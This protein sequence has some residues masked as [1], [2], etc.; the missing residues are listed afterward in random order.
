MPT[1]NPDRFK[2]KVL[3]LNPIAAPDS[4]KWEVDLEGLRLL[5]GGESRHGN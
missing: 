5:V 1:N 3:E 4:A 2:L